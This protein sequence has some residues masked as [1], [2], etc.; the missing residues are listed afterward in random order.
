MKLVGRD[1]FT[2]NFLMIA[3]SPISA[4]LVDLSEFLAGLDLL[5]LEL[6]RSSSQLGSSAMSA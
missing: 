2:Y 4:K 5:Q 3:V 6:G 1:L